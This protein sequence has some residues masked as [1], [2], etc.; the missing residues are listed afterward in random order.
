MEGTV[1][2]T[3]LRS[4]TKKNFFAKGNT[5]QLNSKNVHF[6]NPLAGEEEVTLLGKEYVASD[7]VVS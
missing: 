6:K 4:K 3:A 7:T 1:A 5:N 2:M